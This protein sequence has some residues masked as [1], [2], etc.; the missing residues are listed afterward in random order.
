LVGHDL[1]AEIVCIEAE[2]TVLIAYRNACELDSSDHGSFGV[3]SVRGWIVGNNV[4]GPPNDD[5]GTKGL[6]WQWMP[7]FTPGFV[8]IG[9]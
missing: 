3:L 2:G 8:S 5:Q 7:E 1:E 6:L 9:T 4:D